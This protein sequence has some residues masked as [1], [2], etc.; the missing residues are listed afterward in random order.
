M[1]WTEGADVSWGSAAALAQRHTRGWTSCSAPLEL[2]GE[3]FGEAESFHLAG[4]APFKVKKWDIKMQF[5]FS[6]IEKFTISKQGSITLL[7]VFLRLD[8]LLVASSILGSDGG[9]AVTC[10][11]ALHGWSGKMWSCRHCLHCMQTLFDWRE[12]VLYALPEESDCN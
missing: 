3:L 2:Q 12:R 4:N 6:Q 7:A 9:K 11:G 8:V 1:F 5:L 10:A